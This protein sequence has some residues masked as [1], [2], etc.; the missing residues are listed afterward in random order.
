MNG[1]QFK[2]PKYLGERIKSARINLGLSQEEL[3]KAVEIPRPAISQIESGRRAIDSI[4]LLSFS[5]A[6]RKPISYFVEEDVEEDATIGIL[7]RAKEISERDRSVVDDFI[8]FC[9]DYSLLED[10]LSLDR[11]NPFPT[12][13]YELTSKYDAISAGEKIAEELRGSLKLGSDPIKDLGNM[14][15]AFGIKVLYRNL[16]TSKAWGFSISSENLGQCI[17]VNSGCTVQR[18]TFT[19]AHELGHL[20]MD[21]GHTATIFSELQAPAHLAKNNNL[22]ETRANVFAAAFLMP[23]AGIIA[24]LEKLGVYIDRKVALTI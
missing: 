14:L 20:V 21:R 12:W 24:L 5:R 7:Y 9:R 6:L 18:Q 8:V 13:N 19:L 10:T 23:R 17:F 4:E 15:E 3:A 2:Y 1:D 11:G 16:P 22:L